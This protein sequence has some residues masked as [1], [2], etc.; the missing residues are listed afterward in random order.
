MFSIRPFVADDLD[1][2]SDIWLRAVRATHH[3]LTEEDISFYFPL[4]RHALSIMEI[5][6]LVKKGSRQGFMAMDDNKVEALFLSPEQ[7]GN[8][9]GRHLMEFARKK[10]NLDRALL[11]DVN[12]GNPEALGFYRHLGFRQTGRSSV[13]GSGKP[14]P[15]LHLSLHGAINPTGLKNKKSICNRE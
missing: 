6:V 12:E 15:L 7:R 9:G 1:S 11:V 3:F 5:W 4:V 14:F 8:G 10:I 13:D 2:L